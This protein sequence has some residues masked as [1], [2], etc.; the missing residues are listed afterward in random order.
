MKS[1][2]TV[3][4]VGAGPGDAGLLTMRGAE[5]IG[6]AQVL[7][8]DALVNPDLLRLAP[9]DAEIIFGGK[10]AKDHAIPQEELNQLLVKKAK[11]G[12]TV[13]RLKGGDPYI[14]GRGGEEAEELAAEGIE[15]EVVPG[16]SS[17]IAGPNYAGIPVT[18]RECCSSFTVFTG[19]EEPG[20]TDSSLDWEFLAKFRGTKIMLMGVE[21]LRPVVSQLL[22][23]GMAPKTPVA[24]VRWG[25]TARQQSIEGVLDNIADVVEKAGFAAPAVVV[26]GDV[27]KR[28]G[29]LNWFEKRPLHGKRV[30]VTRTREQAS[31]LSKQL[32]EAGADVLEIPTIKIVAPSLREPMLEALAGL[33]TYEWIVFTSP[34]G[35]TSFFDSF[36]KAFEDL[37]D[38]GGARIAAV[39]PATAAKLKELRLKVDLMPEVYVAGK[40]AE[41][42]KGY[43][44][45]ENVSILLVRAQVATPELPAKLE[46][47]GAIVDD[48]PFYQTVPETEDLTGAV[49]RFEAEGADWITFTSSSTVENFHARFDLPALKKKWPKMKFISI[50]PETTKALK[51]LKLTAHLEAEPHTIDG[52]VKTLK[53]A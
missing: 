48:V 33:N 13:V 45:I 20:K 6:R 19:H 46:E 39:G 15:F 11:L 12:K 40:I 24:L 16:V 8:Y 36:F 52:I 17:F 35:V 2:G 49:A 38:L 18:H 37:R 10:R 22:A 27:V 1:S 14:F 3:Y 21:R 5:L 47:M 9:K 34:N 50:G 41:A 44:D 26:I 30:V 53:E 23:A 7:V 42:F 29:T 43:Q 32:S 31:Q 51:A 4:L 28:R 25:T